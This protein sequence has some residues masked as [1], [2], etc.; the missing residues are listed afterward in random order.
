MSERHL[1]EAQATNSIRSFSRSCRKSTSFLRGNDEISIF[2][3]KYG[4]QN[5]VAP[6]GA[7]AC[8]WSLG[9][10]P[11]GRQM[12]WRAGHA[13]WLS[14]ATHLSCPWPPYP[15]GPST[16]EGSGPWEGSARPGQRLIQDMMS[17]WPRLL[18]LLRAVTGSP[19]R[20]R[21]RLRG[22][23]VQVCMC[24]HVCVCMHVCMCVRTCVLAHT[25]ACMSLC[26]CAHV[27]ECTCLRV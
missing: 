22:V 13:K 8:W 6:R 23:C 26:V 9:G 24:V 7:R 25:C 21:E 2:L 15:P 14:S 27:L 5:M 19:V 17:T 16:G 3:L 4:T 18:S 10:V 12:G 20:S 11:S 1:W